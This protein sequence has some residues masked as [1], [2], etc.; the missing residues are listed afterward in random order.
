MRLVEEAG[1]PDAETDWPAE[2]GNPRGI[3]TCTDEFSF[4]L[5]ASP[6]GV[7]VFAAHP[8]RKGVRLR[9]YGDEDLSPV[10]K[11]VR[12]EEVPGEFLK[13][14]IPCAE[15]GWVSRPMDFTRMDLVWFLNHADDPNATSGHEY[16][17][18][19]LRDIAAG[20][21]ITIDYTTL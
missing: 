1:P 19:S 21:E 20:E 16:N 15:A 11:R 14:C 10:A 4:I 12:A 6:H 17:Y 13:Y 5:R 2:N 8:I 9:L 3:E 7:G 18:M